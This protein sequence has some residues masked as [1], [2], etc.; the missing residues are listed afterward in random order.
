MGRIR[1][2]AQSDT[3]VWNH[4]RVGGSTTAKFVY[5]YIVLTSQ[6]LLMN[7]IHSL[8]WT[9]S[10]PTKI[11]CFIWLVMENKI[12]TWDNLQ[13]KKWIGPGF[14]ALRGDGV[15]C[16][17]HILSSCS[18]WREFIC[19][20]SD[21]YQFIPPQQCDDIT[22]Y[23]RNWIRR[24]T[25]YTLACFIIFFV[26]WTIWKSR[27]ASIFEGKNNSILNIVSQIDQFLLLYK[28][29]CK[30]IKK[31]RDTGTG[32][33]LVYPCGFFDGASTNDI[34]GP[35]I[36]I[37]LNK[38]HSFEFALGLGTSTNTKAELLGLWALLHVAQVMGLPTLNIFG[39]S[40][41]IINWVNGCNALAPPELSH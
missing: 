20:L 8:I 5:E 28:P 16:V 40:S 19:H 23:L 1:L 11:G 22:S 39:D 29:P 9:S 10:L 32:P 35:G 30:K 24:F 3:L 38:D 17:Q 26:L 27:N 4:N 7:N 37:F 34:G 33:L 6:P 21:K 36:Y 13:R 25:K 18:V 14:C 15:D 31:P 2:H 12:L 41:V